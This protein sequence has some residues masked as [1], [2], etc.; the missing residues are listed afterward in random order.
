MAGIYLAIP[1]FSPGLR[2]TVASVTSIVCHGWFSRWIAAQDAGP[3]GVGSYVTPSR[4]FAATAFA[5]N[6][7]GPGPVGSSLKKPVSSPNGPAP[8]HATPATAIMGR[9][10]L[11]R[12]QCM[13]SRFFRLLPPIIGA[14]G[15]LST[16]NHVKQCN[17]RLALRVGRVSIRYQ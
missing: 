9:I 14:G 10:L 11:A 2:G 13:R 4:Q 15:L 5:H 7:P 3:P 8:P 12:Q 6:T 1:I 16:I 17:R